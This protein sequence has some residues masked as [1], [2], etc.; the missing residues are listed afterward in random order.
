MQKE[1][2]NLNELDK[3]GQFVFIAMLR[4]AIWCLELGLDKEKFVELAKG[5]WDTMLMNDPKK[6]DEILSSVMSKNLRDFIEET[7]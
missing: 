2:L 4:S 7:P 3:T 6:L 1:R 5:S